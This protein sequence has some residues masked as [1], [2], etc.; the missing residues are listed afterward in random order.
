[1]PQSDWL[2]GLLASLDRFG[3][4]ALAAS[5][6]IRERNV[7]I[8]VHAQSTGARWRPGRRIEL[9][10]A[11]LGDGA[12]ELY[13]VSLVIHEVRHLQQ[14]I[15]VALSVYGELDAWQAQ[16]GFIRSQTGRNHDPSGRD[17][18]LEELMA[19]P[20]RLN[21]EALGRARQLMRDYAGPRYR[22]D[23]LPLFPVPN[24]IL[25][26]AT[27]RDQETSAPH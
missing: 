2:A 24:E 27:G 5:R 4:E 7:D 6:Y 22:I 11:Y 8:S 17:L 25:W 10:P 21:R 15:L 1:M 18:I 23:L 9:N 3:P 19:L 16:F 13:L 26:L 14:G 20:L 12:R